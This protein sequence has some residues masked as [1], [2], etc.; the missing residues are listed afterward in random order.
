[1]SGLF[2]QSWYRVTDI[3]PQLRANAQWVRHQ[4]RGEIWYVLRDQTGG[5]LHRFSESAKVLIE[6]MD[7][8]KSLK[9]IW[10]D[11]CASLGDDMP[12][13]D[14]TIQLLSQ[15]YRSNVLQ[16]DVMPDLD[17]MFRR[18][19][20]HSRQKWLQYLKSP[21]ALRLPIWNPENFLNRSQWVAQLLFNPV[22]AV[23]WLLVVVTALFQ[24]GVNWQEL[25]NNFSD[26]AFSA[27]NWLIIFLIYPFIKLVHELG[28]GYAVKRWGGEVSE[29]GLMFLVFIPVP[30]IDASSSGL[31]RNK[32][33]RM[34]VAAAGILIEGALAAIALLL[35]V[36]S[37]PGL[38]RAVLFNI[39]LIGG[40]ST[41]LFN[42]NPLLRFDAYYVLSDF[43][44]LPNLGK[45]ANQY[46]GYLL[47]RY[48]LKQEELSPSNSR[49]ESYWLFV[50]SIASFLYR[51]SIFVA[52]ALYVASEFFFI[53]VLLAM[54]SMYQTLLAP[55]IRVLNQVY[56]ESLAKNFRPRL[57][58]SI[59]FA[60]AASYVL[61]FVVPMPN[62]TVAHG[63]VW[64][65]Q[66]MQINSGENCFVDSLLK[67]QSQTV[68]AGEGL[69]S[70][71]SLQLRS[72]MA[73]A[74]AK[75]VE[76]ESQFRA[77]AVDDRIEAAIIRDELQRLL[78]EMDVLQQRLAA[79]T[80]KSPGDGVLR[81][82]QPQQLIGRFVAR[83][84]YLG[85]VDSAGE[86][87][88]RVAVPQDAISKVRADI[89]QVEVR[90][91]SDFS[92]IIIANILREV[93]M[94]STSV[95]DSA[96]TT[97]GG[98][99]VVLDPSAKDQVKA[100]D[101]W[102]QFDIRVNADWHAK[103]GETAYVRFSHSPEPLGLAIWRSIRRTFLKQLAV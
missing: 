31:M 22:T 9:D 99:D 92:T 98:G 73:V 52:I 14:E 1:M 38:F 55:L 35:W 83:G 62:Y 57:L 72:E 84:S 26:Q 82:D 93:P 50:Y 16:A 44:E 43:I 65:P 91:S 78:V 40:V 69:V 59:G 18:Q 5:K 100:L 87:I 60:I 25:S 3:K 45:R 63:V 75:V 54:W 48:V 32:Y 39:M 7:G 67:K 46:V 2:S 74:K 37:E 27:G 15:L 86:K 85:Y 71:R 51:I 17:E 61:L 28:H 53:G 79:L 97:E 29:L 24:M 56:S 47:K 21:L 49:S 12:S 88:V 6:Q 30:Y 89:S 36:N 20:Q 70:C 77:S 8:S 68:T 42:G 94:A 66:E 34:V 13:Q 96:L 81:W 90:A 101:N 103:V 11:S 33:Q 10:H 102:F 23:L 64:A 19:Q 95:I 80:I 76:L 41:L 4:Y 58:L